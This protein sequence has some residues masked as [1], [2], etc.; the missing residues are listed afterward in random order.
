[1]INGGSYRVTYRP[2]K[3][4]Q[5]KTNNREIPSKRLNYPEKEM[6]YLAYSINYYPS[7]SSDFLLSVDGSD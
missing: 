4:T 3:A 6:I 7:K 5:K 1:M 2:H